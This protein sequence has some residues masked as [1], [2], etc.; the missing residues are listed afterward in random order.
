VRVYAKRTP[1]EIE[2]IVE[3]I[4]RVTDR[5]LQLDRFVIVEQTGQASA[6]STGQESA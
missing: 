1:K 3:A 4:E 2:R 6:D 5:E